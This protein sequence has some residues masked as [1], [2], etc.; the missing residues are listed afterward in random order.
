MNDNQPP[1]LPNK[2]EISYDLG[3]PGGDLT[4]CLVTRVLENGFKVIAHLEGEDAEAF[5]DAWN[6]RAASP[7][8]RSDNSLTLSEILQYND[9]S[10]AL[11]ERLKLLLHSLEASQPK[12]QQ[13]EGCN[14]HSCRI[15]K[16]T[17][18][19]TNGP[20]SCPKPQQS[21]EDLVLEVLKPQSTSNGQT[22]LQKRAAIIA[23]HRQG[24][25]PVP[26]SGAV[27]VPMSAKEWPDEVKEGI[28]WLMARIAHDDRSI[29]GGHADEERSLIKYINNLRA[30][31][32]A[33]HPA[34]DGKL[35]DNPK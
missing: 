6:S 10:D 31:V 5:I 18:M 3:Q 21:D 23:R 25:V 32:R 33:Q 24:S 13:A 1:L 19:A 14:S 11:R 26:T 12:P 22:A 35:S 17:G 27:E 34:A 16:P 2:V 7:V 4:S 20:C 15:K 28:M 29:Y 9:M 8:T 30:Q